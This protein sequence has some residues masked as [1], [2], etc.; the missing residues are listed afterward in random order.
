MHCKTNSTETQQRS[1]APRRTY[2]SLRAGNAPAFPQSSGSVPA[3]ETAERAFQLAKAALITP[4]HLSR[5]AT[6]HK[7]TNHVFGR[8]LP[9][10]F[11]NRH[12]KLV[13]NLQ[14]GRRRHVLG[15]THCA[16]VGWSIAALYATML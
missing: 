7:K 6:T 8:V 15:V 4:V 14:R 10:M 3:G 11:S 5:L 2:S 16:Q 12:L 9:L 1:A 13:M